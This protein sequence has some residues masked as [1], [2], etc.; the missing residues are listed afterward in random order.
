MPVDPDAPGRSA[1]APAQFSLAAWRA[2]LARTWTRIGEDH[3]SMIAAGVAFY[4]MFSVFPGVAA[5][6]AVYGLVADPDSIRASLHAMEP[7]LPT[8]VHAILAGQVEEIIGAGTSALGITTAVST[9]VALWTARTGVMALIQG[10][11]IAYREDDEH[12]FL[13]QYVWALVLT[14]GLVVF[15]VLV[16]LVV[17]ALP[18]VLRFSDFGV[19]GALLAQLTPV[20]VIGAAMVFGIGG[21]YRFGPHRSP[22]RMRWITVGAVAATLG[23]VAVSLAL[24]VYFTNFAN[25]NRVYGSLGA[26]IGLMFWM[27]ASAFVVLIGASLNAAM[28]LQ[29]ARDT[30]TGPERPMGRR[31]AYVADHVE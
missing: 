13:M 20:L 18:V 24:S 2:V 15:A 23:W 11:N 28:E 27:W 6:I 16:L 26:I 9:A 30:T 8:D 17:V 21:L 31:G 29:T 10:L 5:L 1:D 7:L 25:F 22:A 4:W 3:L 12:G 19:A 14:V